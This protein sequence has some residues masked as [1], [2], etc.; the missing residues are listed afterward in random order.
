MSALSVSVAVDGGQ[1]AGLMGAL[2]APWW[3]F[4]G[5]AVPWARCA[6]W[7]WVRVGSGWERL[8]AFKVAERC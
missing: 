1:E 7:R 8:W 5:G 6:P 4:G 3:C 2:G